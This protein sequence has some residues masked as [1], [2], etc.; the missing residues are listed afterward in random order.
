MHGN[1]TRM[2]VTDSMPPLST[3]KCHPPPGSISRTKIIVVTAASSHGRNSSGKRRRSARA[4]FFDERVLL[5]YFAR[6]GLDATRND[7][8]VTVLWTADID[9]FEPT[10]FQ[11]FV[12][13][14]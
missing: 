10:N 13:S 5:G 12:R 4:S 14:W 11:D 9:K 1:G 7:G 2:L 6:H 8:L 3:S